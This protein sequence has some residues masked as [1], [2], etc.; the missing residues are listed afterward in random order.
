MEFSKEDKL[1]LYRNMVYIRQFE[2]RMME[3]FASGVMP[4]GVHLG[5][6]Q[7]ACMA[8]A[9]FP[10][11]EGDTIGSTHREHGVLLCM[12][13]DG[14]RIVAEFAGKKTGYCGGKGGEMHACEPGRGILGNNAILGPAQTI[15]NGFAFANKMRKNGRVA[16]SMFGEGASNRGEFHE[17]MNLA[18]LWKLPSIFILTDNGFAFS[19]PQSNQQ[20]IRELSVRAY[21]YDMPGVTIDG[22]D[23]LAVATEV[24]AAVK[25]AREGGGPSLIELKTLRWRGH[26]EGDPAAYRSKELL[27]EWK[28]PAK[29]PIARFEKVLLDTKTATQEDFGQIHTEIE[30]KIDGHVKFAQES[31]YPPLEDMYV[32]LYDTFEERGEQV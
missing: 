4:G 12:G 7:E 11:E 26:S 16:V 28:S 18:S 8:G 22:N 3:I 14:D 23:V 10:L 24:S 2:L 5:L 1:K 27:A 25:R 21:G 20:S 9:C 32:G 31:E 13:M 19:N 6:G 30:A 15:I 17:G 29:E